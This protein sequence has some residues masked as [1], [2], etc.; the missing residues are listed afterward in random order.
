MNV[1]FSKNVEFQYFVAIVKKLK[2]L[3]RLDR[4]NMI[5]LKRYHPAE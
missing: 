1:G 2:V 5:Y 3:F 4:S